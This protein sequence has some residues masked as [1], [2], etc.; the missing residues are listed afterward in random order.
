MFAEVFRRCDSAGCF[1]DDANNGGEN[2]EN[3]GG[4]NRR[5]GENVS[6]NDLKYALCLYF[7]GKCW[8]S[9]R[10]EFVPLIAG[11]AEGEEKKTMVMNRELR[12]EHVLRGKECLER[13]L[14]FASA[15]RFLPRGFEKDARA[16][17]GLIEEDDDDDDDD[18]DDGGTTREAM[19]TPEA[20]R[21][22]KVKRFKKQS[23][24]RR[25]L[26]E[27]EKSGVVD[28]C[29]R[30]KSR[31]A[32]EE[33]EEEGEEEADEE[34][35]REY[36][37]A[38]I[39]KAVLDSIEMIEGSKEEVALLTGVSEVE[40][41][42]IVQGGEKKQQRG[43]GGGEFVLENSRGAFKSH[44]VSGEQQEQQRNKRSKWNDEPKRAAGWYVCADGCDPVAPV[45]LI[46]ESQGKR[47]SRREKRFVSAFAHFT[48]NVYRRSRRNRAERI[49]GAHGTE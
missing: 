33:E 16:A 18:D 1:D 46:R 24:L 31:T 2:E 39:E 19:M 21:T 35:V 49:N 12:V 22:M 7:Q 9:M 14:R 42:R 11:E 44:R 28:R 20:K 38:M 47:R 27:M 34:K 5:G 36:W 25:K 15:A 4:D 8:Q 40:V 37:F 6:T 30:V 41:R 13:F 43:G 23:E 48:H 3:F 32:E 10:T 29:A 26:E 45:F 17:A